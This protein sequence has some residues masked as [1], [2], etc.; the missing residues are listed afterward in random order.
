[1]L[2]NEMEMEIKLEKK[3][4]QTISKKTWSRE[5]KKNYGFDDNDGS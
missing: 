1:M 3:K 2:W 4:L 5:K